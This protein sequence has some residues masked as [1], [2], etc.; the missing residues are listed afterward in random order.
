MECGGVCWKHCA[1]GID[2][3][4]TFPNGELLLEAL[5]FDRR[6]GRSCKHVVMRPRPQ[7]H[8]SARDDHGSNETNECDTPKRREPGKDGHSLGGCRMDAEHSSAP[9]SWRA[10][11][12]MLTDLVRRDTGTWWWGLDHRQMPGRCRSR[13]PV[14]R[15]SDPVAFRTLP[16][17]RCRR[18]RPASG[19]RRSCWR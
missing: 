15:Y 6:S 3:R 10:R 4:R 14:R 8:R 11:A 17:G 18:R 16:R 9:I 2:R 7:R 5:H 13:D 1:V 19:G 12:G